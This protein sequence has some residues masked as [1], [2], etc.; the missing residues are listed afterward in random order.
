MNKKI[1]LGVCISLIAVACAVTFVLTMRISQDMY[2]QRIAGVGQREAIYDKLQSIDSYVRSNYFGTIAEDRLVTGIM[3]GYMTGL[4]DNKS[5]YISASEFYEFSQYMKGRIVTAGVQ[6]VRNENGYIRITEVYDGSS[7]RM[8]GIEAGDIITQVGGAPVLEIGA[9]NAI[10]LLSGDEGVRISITIQ[11]DGEE[12]RY[13]LTQQEIDLITVR[14]I[15]HGEIGYIRVLS[16]ADN[17][18]D[19]FDTIINEMIAGDIKGLILDVRGLSGSLIPPQRQILD[20]LLPRGAAAVAEYRNGSINNIIEIAN[21]AH[22]NLPI[23][24]ITDGGTAEGGELI[25]AALRDYAGAQL[26][27]T[28]TKG[29]PM[30]TAVQ[31]LGDGS[32]LLLSVKKV[33][34]GGGTSFDGEGIRPDFLIELITPPET[35]LDNL[36]NTL[37][38]QIRKA[39]EVTETRISLNTIQEEQ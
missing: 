20:R 7:A 11:R 17:T 14:G 21:E 1:S 30:F 37:D 9:E 36:E 16:F 23:T 27:G 24:V 33:R 38:L 8:L 10:R 13:T 19:Q 31:T 26:V 15:T 39:I 22:I 6:V 2:N 3:S 18:S 5:R 34:S 29:D 25:A 32:A 35:D 28:A 4:G 12:H